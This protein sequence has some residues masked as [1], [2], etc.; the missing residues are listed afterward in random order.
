MVAVI[1]NQIFFYCISYVAILIKKILGFHCC[2]SNYV[3]QFIIIAFELTLS[4][5]HNR[6]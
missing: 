1:I 2:V 5:T 6:Q 4:C 3:P